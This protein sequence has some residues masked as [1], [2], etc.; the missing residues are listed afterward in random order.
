M[1]DLSVTHSMLTGHIRTSGI[2]IQFTDVNRRTA[3]ALGISERSVR[4]IT[5]EEKVAP[6]N[7]GPPKKKKRIGSKKTQLDSF[8]EGIV[9]RQFLGFYQQKEFNTV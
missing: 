3:E 2:P 4:R 9:R 7:E 8:G 1:F 6:P 5:S